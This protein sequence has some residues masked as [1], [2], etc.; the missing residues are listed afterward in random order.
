MDVVDARSRLAPTPAGEGTWAPRP[1]IP[2]RENHIGWALEP[3]EKDVRCSQC[4]ALPA[5]VDGPRPR[6]YR[7]APH[8][9]THSAEALPALVSLPPWLTEPA[10]PRQ[11]ALLPA[12]HAIDDAMATGQT[13]ADDGG[14]AQCGRGRG[15]GTRA[16]GGGGGGGGGAVHCP[17]C[18]PAH[19]RH[20]T[21]PPGPINCR[22][23]G[24]GMCRGPRARRGATQFVV[25]LACVLPV[26]PLLATTW[27]LRPG[28]TTQ[29]RPSSDLYLPTS[30]GSRPGCRTG[31]IEPPSPRVNPAG[32]GKQ[33]KRE[34]GGG[35]ES[36][37]SSGSLVP[38]VEGFPI[39]I[40]F[41]LRAPLCEVCGTG[42]DVRQAMASP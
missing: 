4:E 2:T 41:K 35:R 7:G 9:A 24:S 33:A 5:G 11:R 1:E 21:T 10:P 26:P 25:W 42:T 13:K 17:N 20:P 36:F 12:G 19:C 3:L 34:G 18:L 40:V 15:G 16:G 37:R 8:A 14:G 29:P 39:S 23:Q 28:T 6:P 30:L 31:P 32:A 38:C 27:W 22:A